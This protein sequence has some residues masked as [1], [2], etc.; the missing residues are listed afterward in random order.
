MT[1]GDSDETAE[2]FLTSDPIDMQVAVGILEEEGIK[3]V[4]RDLHMSACPFNVGLL[5]E[6]RLVVSIWDADQARELLAQGVADGEL[7]GT[8]L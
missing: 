8:P 2:V 6:L 1:A 5:G 4:V 3:A 7:T